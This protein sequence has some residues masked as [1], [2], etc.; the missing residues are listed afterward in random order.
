M[1]GWI[2]EETE[3]FKSALQAIGPEGHDW[4]DTMVGIRWYLERDPMAVGHGTQDL[5]VR[6]LMW[7]TPD[8]L[9]DLKIFY[10]VEPGK[11]TLLSVKAADPLPF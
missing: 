5:E 2:V 4:S 11:V 7:D 1:A 9:A 10:L 3:Y 8:G 6:I